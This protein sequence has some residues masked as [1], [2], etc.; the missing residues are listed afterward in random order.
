MGEQDPAP[1]AL[2]P[3]VNARRVPRRPVVA[4]PPKSR[5]ARPPGGAANPAKR[6]GT[7]QENPV[8]SVR[9]SSFRR[10]GRLARLG[11]GLLIRPAP[12]QIRPGSLHPDAQGLEP[13]VGVVPERLEAPS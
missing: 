3:P 6:R 5:F 9:I 7:P 4:R 12:V 10:A 11:N 2:V 1:R 8:P 13:G